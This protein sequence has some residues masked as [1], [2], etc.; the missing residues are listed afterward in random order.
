MRIPSRTSSSVHNPLFVGVLEG[1]GPLDDPDIP[2]EVVL[3][4]RANVS[5]EA[6]SPTSPKARHSLVSRPAT[7]ESSIGGRSLKQATSERLAAL[8]VTRDTVFW[9]RDLTDFGIRVYPIGGKVY[10]AQARGPEGPDKPKRVTL[11]RHGVI[12]AE[13]ARRRAALI[14]VRIKAGEE[15]VPLPLAVKAV[16]GPTVANLAARYPEEHV[17]VRVKPKTAVKAR[18]AVRRQILPAPRP[19]AARGGGARSGCR[20]TT[21]NVRHPVGRQYGG[22]DP[23]GAPTGRE[24]RGYDTRNHRTKR[25]TH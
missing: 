18:I 17:A 23:Y 2:G 22:E 7:P 4:T 9:D 15:P 25:Q 5:N 1:G 10:V 8:R 14:I 3:R 19:G 6:E 20:T 24:R 11:G 12:G 13:Q 16:G 21:Q